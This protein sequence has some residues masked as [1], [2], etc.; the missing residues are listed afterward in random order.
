[1]EGLHYDSRNSG[2][3]LTRARARGGM[4]ERAPLAWIAL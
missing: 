3:P 1:M 4:T 2:P